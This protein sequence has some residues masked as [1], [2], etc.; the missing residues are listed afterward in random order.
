MVANTSNPPATIFIREIPKLDG[1][2]Y[3]I[4][5]IR[6]ENHL[7]CL[8]KDIWEITKKGYTPYDLASG[9]PA[10]ADLDKNIENDC[11]ATKA[12]LCALT[13]KKIM[14]LTNKSLAK[15][16]WD[17]LQTLNE[18][19]PT[20]KI[21]K[22]D[23]YRIRYENL[24]MD[25]NERITTFM[26]RVNE[27]VMGFQCYGGYLSEDETVSKVL[28]SLP[29]AYKMKATAINELRT[30]ANTSVNKDIQIGKLSVFELE[31]FGSSGAVKSEPSF[32]ASS[33]TS[34]S[35]WKALYAKEMEDMRKEDE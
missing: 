31:E 11:R 35:D 26:E 32:H 5:K 6:M 30:M 22:L 1:T 19:D 9:N 12:L 29:P 20:F 3:G 13:D 4:W 23:G 10:P 28:R 8:G 21:A 2:N 14:G 18:G 34:K 25:D 7:R 16:M 24:K 27:I 17:K 33:S 15:D